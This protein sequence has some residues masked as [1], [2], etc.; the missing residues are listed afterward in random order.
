MTEAQLHRQIAGLLRAWLLPPAIFT[1]FPAGGGG[2]MR[3]KFL[4]ASGL[5]A[6]WPDIQIVHQ[7]RLYLIELKTQK[8]RVSPAQVECHAELRGAGCAVAVCRSLEDVQAALDEW[9]LPKRRVSLSAQR[10]Q[11][12]CAQTAAASRF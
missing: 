9:H 11:D 6:G 4:R 2:E 3:G 12:A 1:T 8:G 10:L 5:K 7:G